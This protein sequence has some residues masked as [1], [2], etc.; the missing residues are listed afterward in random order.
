MWDVAQFYTDAFM[1]DLERLNIDK[2][3]LFSLA[4]LTI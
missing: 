2:N 3:N 4:L 1:S